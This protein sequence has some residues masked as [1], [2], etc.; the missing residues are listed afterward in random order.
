MIR[1]GISGWRYAPWRGV[2]Y[3][4]GLSQRCELHFASRVL[5]SVEINGSFYS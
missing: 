5:R 2:F 1:V 4:E 3:P